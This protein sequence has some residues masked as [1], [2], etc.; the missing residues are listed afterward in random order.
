[1]SQQGA[2]FGGAVFYQANFPRHFAAAPEKSSAVISCHF[3]P[4]HL[5]E[6][7]RV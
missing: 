6:D 7:V 2:N 4:F 1:M 5:R 3:P